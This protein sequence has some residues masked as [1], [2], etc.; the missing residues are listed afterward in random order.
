MP[1]TPRKT[2]ASSANKRTIAQLPGETMENERELREAQVGFVLTGMTSKEIAARLFPLIKEDPDKLKQA[3]SANK[4][5]E[6]ERH[7]AL[8]TLVHLWV[9]E[10]F[11]RGELP[12]SSAKPVSCRL[13]F[14]PNAWHISPTL[15]GWSGDQ[16]SDPSPK[17]NGGPPLNPALVYRGK[18]LR[19]AR[20][21]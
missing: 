8:S 11:S 13:H 21:S 14:A 1:F 16:Q 15:S 12:L 3:G 7:A 19:F 17:Q 5:N 10:K 2:P 4:G 9:L 18:I 20:T 6:D